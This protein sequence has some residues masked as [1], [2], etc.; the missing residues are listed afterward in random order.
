MEQ[1][2]KNKLLSETSYRALG[3]LGGVEV[4]LRPVSNQQKSALQIY[5]E[6]KKMSL[7]LN[8]PVSAE[9]IDFIK[10]DKCALWAGGI[11]STIALLVYA[12]APKSTLKPG[13]FQKLKMFFS[14]LKISFPKITDLPIVK[15]FQNFVWANNPLVDYFF[16]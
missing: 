1:K 14:G 15:S 10:S 9:A 8:Q 11:L 4:A 16:I 7:D 13:I 3:A 2:R 5:A 12:F 6:K